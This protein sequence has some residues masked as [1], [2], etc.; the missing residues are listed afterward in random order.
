MDV[1]VCVPVYRAHGAPN[2]A[3]LAAALPA[4]LGGREGELVVTL[5]GLSAADAGIPDGVRT[6]AHAENLGVAPGWNSAARVAQGDVLVFANDD[7]ELGPGALAALDDVVRR[8]PEA[9]IA[10]PVGARWD[11]AAGQH[12]QTVDGH[13]LA[14]GD[15]REV[16]A[17]SGFLFAVR[18]EVFERVGGFDEAYAPASWEEVD[19]ACAVR[20]AGLRSYVVGGLDV[21]HEWGI[22]ARAPVWQR[23]RWGGRS[24]LLWSIHRRNRRHF[25]E[26]WS[27]WAASQER[28]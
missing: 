1:S 16:D 17:V 11:F 26:K 20:A 14:R 12:L 15:L 8:H 3:T 28:A 9:G 23:V 13:D 18:R 27:A 25:L 6:V 7:V 22:S 19:L 4:A 10:G 5:N 2:A 24:E 21:G